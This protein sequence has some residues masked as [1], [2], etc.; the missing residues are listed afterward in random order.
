MSIGVADPRGRVWC[1]LY[2][3]RTVL[4]LHGP[5]EWHIH[6]DVSYLQHSTL[7]SSCETTELI[8]LGCLNWQSP[9]ARSFFC[10]F[11][12]TLFT[13]V[14]FRK[15]EWETLHS[16][17]SQR[18]KSFFCQLL[19][20]SSSW[21]TFRQTPLRELTRFMCVHIALRAASAKTM[22]YMKM[23]PQT[24]LYWNPDRLNNPFIFPA[25]NKYPNIISGL[26]DCV[27]LGF[28]QRTSSWVLV[29]EICYTSKVRQRHSSAAAVE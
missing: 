22:F 21:D 12:R 1:G 10:C 14:W 24:F 17:L 13:V 28:L 15:R 9:W 29:Q 4:Y 16:L 18:E 26:M 19:F 7:S 11:S 8:D 2:Y 20:N 3:V 27:V 23:K 6:R 5:S 25:P